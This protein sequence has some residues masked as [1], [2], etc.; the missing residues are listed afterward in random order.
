[1]LIFPFLG[2]PV[3]LEYFYVIILGAIIGM[4]ALF[5]QY[6]SGLFK[7]ENE[8]TSLHEYVKELKHKFKQQTTGDET[9]TKEKTSRISDVSVQQDD[10]E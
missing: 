6:K 10:E 5:I 3:I 1:M 9:L 2:L 8:E 4:T 7:K